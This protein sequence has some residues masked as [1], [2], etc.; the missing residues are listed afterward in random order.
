M[1]SLTKK[2]SKFLC[3][4][5]DYLFTDFYPDMKDLFTGRDF[6]YLIMKDGSGDCDGYMP[7]L[8]LFE[9][10]YIIFSFIVAFC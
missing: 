6:F 7:V 1:L 8:F 5:V 10:I 3:L 2:S 4:F 9:S